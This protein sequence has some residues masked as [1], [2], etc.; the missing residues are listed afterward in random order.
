[1][2]LPTRRPDLAPTDDAARC[3]PA[4]ATSEEPGMY[5][6]AAVDGSAATIWA[7]DPAATTASLTVDLGQATTVTRIT[8]R[9]TYVLPT[10]SLVLISVDGTTWTAAP[11]AGADGSL[12]APVTA[13][14]VRVEF[15]RDP[16]ADRT[17][18][19]ELEVIRATLPRAIGARTG[20]PSLR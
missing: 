2:R 3:K 1:M 4:Q 19:R 18:L 5:A 20:S 8:P 14:Y 7:P 10:S 9:W 6:E 16:T 17:G 15:T 13:R 11:V 12:T